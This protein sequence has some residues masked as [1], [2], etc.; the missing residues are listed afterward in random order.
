MEKCGATLKSVHRLK[1]Q[2]IREDREVHRWVGSDCKQVMIWVVCV[3]AVGFI[4]PSV[5]M[6]RLSH[7]QGAHL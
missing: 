4:S 7:V 5:Q 1:F 6:I 3:R 2:I